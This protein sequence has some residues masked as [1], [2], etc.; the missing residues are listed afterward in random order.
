VTAE[1]GQHRY[2]HNGWTATSI[3]GSSWWTN[4]SVDVAVR[5]SAWQSESD[6]IDI[7]YQDAQDMYRVRFTGGSAIVFS[8]VL[9]NGTQYGAGADLGA[10]AFSYSGGTW[11]DLTVIASGSLFTVKVNGVTLLTVADASIS[12]GRIGFDA[13]AS[14]EYGT[15]TVHS[16]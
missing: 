15:V 5:P 10:V 6:G 9:N 11:Y 14:V 4:Y 1:G 8:R 12:A 7:R 3:A 16:V 13:N 2:S